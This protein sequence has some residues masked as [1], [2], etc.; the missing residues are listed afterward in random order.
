[1]SILLSEKVKWSL[2]QKVSHALTL[3]D[4]YYHHY[5]GKVYLGFSGGKDSVLLRWLCNK[6][7]DACGYP[8]IKCVFNNTTNEHT[9]ILAFVKSFGDEITWLKPKITFAQSIL[10]N[11][12]PL[13]SKEQAQ[14][15][16]EA[17]TTNSDK[18]RQLRM[19]GRNKVSKLGGKYKQ[20]GIADKWTFLVNDDIKVTEKCCD[21]LKKNPAKKFEK[22]TGLKAII[23]VTQGEGGLRKQRAQMQDYCNTYGDRPVSKPLNIFTESDVWDLLLTNKIPYCEI[24]NDQVIDGLIITGEKRTGCAYCAFGVHLEDSDNNKFTRLYYRDRKR[25]ISM[26]DKLGY[27]EA[28]KKIGIKL[29]DNEGSQFK[30]F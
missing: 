4:E 14:Y 11:G 3:I 9:E 28:L 20:G 7:T 26:M 30:L 21:I 25:Y 12:Y 15:I 24:Y 16:R 23:G 8:R 5:N 18:L 27:R 2:D 19:F 6:F 1:M 29:P 22:E 10:I 13:I 17:K